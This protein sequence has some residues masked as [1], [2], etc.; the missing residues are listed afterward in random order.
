MPALV[1][2][3]EEE[4]DDTNIKDPLPEK[5]QNSMV[6]IFIF[7]LVEDGEVQVII[8]PGITGLSLLAQVNLS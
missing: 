7:I 4:E 2:S 3:D 6:T 1:E 8:S 5:L